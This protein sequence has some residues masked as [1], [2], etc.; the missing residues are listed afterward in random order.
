MFAP[1]LG[2]LVFLG[3]PWLLSENRSRIAWRPVLTGLAVL[4]G[5]AWFFLYTSAGRYF[6]EKSGAGITALLDC[7]SQGAASMFHV[8]LISGDLM[9]TA[10]SILPSIIFIGALTAVLYH[11][12]ILQLV[13]RA[14]AL[15]LTRLLGTS[16][17]ES[18][19]AAG[20]IFLCMVEAPLLVRPYLPKFSRSEIFCMMTVGMATI[21][22][23][24]MVV[25][26]GFL[27]Q[28]GTSPGHLLIASILSIFSA[29]VIAK[30]ML[31]ETEKT[32]EEMEKRTPSDAEL[33]PDANLIDAA[34]RG[35]GE[36]MTLSINVLAMLI[37]FA[38]LIAFVN[39]LFSFFGDVGAAPL[40]LQRIFGWAF[41]P[42]AWLLGIPAAECG[43]AGQLLGEKTVLNEF[44]AYLSMAQPE[45]A[46]L[47]SARSRV[48][49][50]YAL[51]GFA[52]FG[53]LAIMVG[54]LGSILPER[55]REIAEL[56]LR[57][58]VS[59]TLAAF[60][61]AALAAIFTPL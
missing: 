9:C 24:V 61:T 45:N 26:A 54:G 23:G 29:I 25:Y 3:I 46:A 17:A 11:L 10:L 19:I 55:R 39:L 30:I 15:C 4:F 18:L 13:T 27:Q 41:A 6:Q 47:L 58:L 31:P 52:N 21:A 34:C 37:A 59:G 38:A 20:S 32:P 60:I 33:R 53:S 7:A 5:L 42:V 44:L 40:T 22:G 35:A 48:I 57:S 14:F 16:G 28:C 50:S 56:A 2:I 49:L 43:Y 1:L 12:G 8:R 51:C 36:G